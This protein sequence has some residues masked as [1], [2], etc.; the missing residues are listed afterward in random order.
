MLHWRDLARPVRAARHEDTRADER[1]GWGD[2]PVVS[3][4]LQPALGQRI[5]DTGEQRIHG[6]G[7]AQEKQGFVRLEIER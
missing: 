7:L 5:L 4:A 3:S 2:R 1:G 6:V